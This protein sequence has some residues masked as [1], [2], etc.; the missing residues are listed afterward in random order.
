M[1]TRTV[2][3]GFRLSLVSDTSVDVALLLREV[4]TPAPLRE[5]WGEDTRRCY[6]G[7]PAQ[8]MVT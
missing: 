5:E 7:I 6:P 3:P 1:C 4:M 8:V 2:W